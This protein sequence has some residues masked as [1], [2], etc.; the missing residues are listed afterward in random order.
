MSTWQVWFFVAILLSSISIT[1][2]IFAQKDSIPSPLKQ[3]KSGISLSA[4]KCEQGYVLIVRESKTEPACV[5]P[6]S[7]ARLVAHSWIS[8]EEFV[9]THP[10]VQQN[11]TVTPMPQNINIG[12]N[13]IITQNK[14]NTTNH[15]PIPINRTIPP[16]Q[17][18]QTGQTSVNDVCVP[19]VQCPF[20]LEWSGV[21]CQIVLWKSFPIPAQVSY[22]PQVFSAVNNQCPA[23][24]TYTPPNSNMSNGQPSGS[25]GSCMNLNP[26]NNSSIPF[27]KFSSTGICPKNYQF[28]PALNGEDGLCFALINSP[29]TSSDLCFP[30]SVQGNQCVIG[31][32]SICGPN[33]LPLSP[34]SNICVAPPV[35]NQC[36]KGYVPNTLTGIC[37][38][39]SNA[40]TST[41]ILSVGQMIFGEL[42]TQITPNSVIV[43]YPDCRGSCS[44]TITETIPIG[45]TFDSIQNCWSKT[46][47]KITLVSTNETSAT[48]SI[49]SSFHPYGYCPVCLSADSIINTPNGDVNVKDIKDG[50][51][52]WSTDSNGIIVKSKVIKI[53]SV[54]VGDT[55]KVIDLQ[56][57]DGRELFVSPKHP[58]Y[59]GRII[60][61]LKVGETYDGAAVKSTELVQYKYQFTYDILPDSQTGFYWANGILV[62]STLR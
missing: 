5:K 9:K 41:Q 25:N 36:D 48:F 3:L 32:Q 52:V 2:A 61:D 56:L 8:I 40:V 39:S 46:L 59:D 22:G 62:G 43:Q 47:D 34:G 55:H 27:N 23:G 38:A 28:Y 54:F 4:I 50:M 42:V 26:W 1:P 53:N 58:T 19:T 49:S 51:T 13:L 20:G 11:Q 21:Q 31:D 12:S 30:Y 29:P 7:L 18:C 45:K 37:T 10:I 33:T 60:A 44:G 35:K 14:S 16:V 57:S 6:L 17:S 24:Y 15:S